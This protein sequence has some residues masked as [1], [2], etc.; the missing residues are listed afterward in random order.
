MFLSITVNT[1][2]YGSQIYDILETL[3]DS[4]VKIINISE[5]IRFFEEE[6]EEG[7]HDNGGEDRTEGK[8][9]NHTIDQHIWLNPVYAKQMVET[10]STGIQMVDK[11]NATSYQA[12][13]KEYVGKLEVLN[14][15]FQGAESRYFIV[16][17]A[18]F[19]YLAR[20]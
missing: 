2:K 19:A 3:A 10:I 18:A 13:T 15:E 17:H 9:D 20:R 7:N 16:Q 11:G 4:D 8:E 1:W 12:N 14:Q 6:I 5:G